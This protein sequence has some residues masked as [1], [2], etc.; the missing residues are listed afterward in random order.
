MYNNI[1]ENDVNADVLNQSINGD[2]LN[3]VSEQEHSS[4]LD[5]GVGTQKSWISDDTQGNAN[6][7]SINLNVNGETELN[8]L[9][10]SRSLV[11]TDIAPPDIV[12]PGLRIGMNST[13]NSTVPQTTQIP[14]NSADTHHS[15]LNLNNSLQ[16]L[17]LSTPT[18]D[19]TLCSI[20]GISIFN[21]KSV[22]AVFRNSPHVVVSCDA[23]TNKTNTAR[24]AGAS[25]NWILRKNQSWE[26]T[27]RAAT[28]LKISVFS[29]GS[30][31][32]GS[33]CVNTRELIVVPRDAQG[34]TVVVRDLEHNLEVTGKVRLVMNLAFSMEKTE[35]VQVIFA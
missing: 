25:A 17:S 11:P 23:F 26:I 29:N 15:I 1:V 8:T 7:N 4:I 24:F 27:M 9:R 10:N 21:C 35:A 5:T 18:P 33:V 19:I 13:S 34:L 3:A 28:F 32:V 22:S 16:D 20:L 30:S 12:S 6:E 2:D 14:H 31:L